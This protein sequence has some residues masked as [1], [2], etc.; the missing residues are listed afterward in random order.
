VQVD[1]LVLVD[2]DNESTESSDEV[3]LGEISMFEEL[4]ERFERDLSRQA[5]SLMG[6]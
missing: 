3:T 5:G 6:R 4:V 2:K 1:D